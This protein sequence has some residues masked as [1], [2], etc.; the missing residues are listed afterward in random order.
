MTV[1][2]IAVIN[3]WSAWHSAKM[4]ISLLLS[5]TIDQNKDFYRQNNAIIGYLR[6]MMPAA[7]QE[8]RVDELLTSLN[9]IY[10]K[11]DLVNLERSAERSRFRVY[12][13]M[14]VKF[15]SVMFQSIFWGTLV[16]YS[17]KEIMKV[18]YPLQHICQI[19]V[20][21]A[22]D[23]S[24]LMESW[25]DFLIA[26]SFVEDAIQSNPEPFPRSKVPTLNSGDWVTLRIDHLEHAYPNNGPT[27][28][29][30]AV[31][32][33]PVG[34]TGFCGKNGAGKTTLFNILSGYIKAE[35]LH[36]DS[37]VTMFVHRDGSI[38]EIV[39]CHAE[40]P[41]V[42]GP[43]SC[44]QQV[45]KKK[46]FYE[47]G[48][49]FTQVIMECRCQNDC[50]C[51]LSDDV[52]DAFVSMFPNSRPE[53]AVE[54]LSHDEEDKQVDYQIQDSEWSVLEFFF[55]TVPQAPGKTNFWKAPCELSAGQ[56][57]MLKF[58]VTY[59]KAARAK[60]AIFDE[61]GSN[62]DQDNIG[63]MSHLL[64]QLATKMP[65]LIATHQ[66]STGLAENMINQYMIQDRIVGSMCSI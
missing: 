62:V 63:V 19:M 44:Y 64:D 47:H 45:N 38:D 35:D 6:N 16:D 51:Q 1:F 65:V 40:I 23:T 24:H 58:L 21:L 5:T 50:T 37:Q 41:G 9:E 46:L 36:E 39:L 28:A 66:R 26:R 48:R 31:I 11:W 7:I 32:D 17:T 2:V 4:K 54:N 10:I 20:G 61:P 25:T 3:R 18:Y 55:P 29:A 8:G 52:K 56:T 53:D 12:K 42:L 60:I 15:L 30:S 22:Q 33:I 14:W 59:Q 34:K 13:S 43:L 57:A 27:L 49:T